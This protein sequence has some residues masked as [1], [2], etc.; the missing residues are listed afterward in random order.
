MTASGQVND[1]SNRW[2]RYVRIPL[3]GHFA[4]G[5]VHVDFITLFGVLKPHLNT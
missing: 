2:L 3:A 1:P 4:G 5:I